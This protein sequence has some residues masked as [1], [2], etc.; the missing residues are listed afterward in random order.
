MERLVV[1]V[2]K[3]L[4]VLPPLFVLF[5]GYRDGIIPI[6]LFSAHGAIKS[7]ISTIKQSQNIKSID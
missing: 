4:Q 6:Y 5:S 3:R 1:C 2:A 7:C